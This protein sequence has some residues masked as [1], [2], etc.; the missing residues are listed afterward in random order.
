MCETGD[1]S[2]K[3]LRRVR[4]VETL[5]LSALCLVTIDCFGLGPGLL[6]RCRLKKIPFHH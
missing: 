6:D 5:G 1:A 4:S 2:M 3:Y